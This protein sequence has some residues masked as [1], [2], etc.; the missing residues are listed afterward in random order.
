MVEGREEQPKGG[1]GMTRRDFLGSIVEPFLHQGD[2]YRNLDEQDLSHPDTAVTKVVH[3]IARDLDTLD[4]GVPPPPPDSFDLRCRLPQENID[5]ILQ[6]MRRDQLVQVMRDLWLDTVAIRLF[7]GLTRFA[8]GDI[9]PNLIYDVKALMNKIANPDIDW[10]TVWEETKPPDKFEEFYSY[11][12]PRL[13][14]G[15]IS[16]AEMI[17]DFVKKNITTDLEAEQDRLHEWAQLIT[18]SFLIEAAFLLGISVSED[19][20]IEII[21]LL[22]SVLIPARFLLGNPLNNAIEGALSPDL[23][24]TDVIANPVTVEGYDQAQRIVQEMRDSGPPATVLLPSDEHVFVHDTSVETVPGSCWLD[25]NRFVFLTDLNNPGIIRLPLRPDTFGGLRVVGATG[26]VLAEGTEGNL[27]RVPATINFSEDVELQDLTTPDSPYSDSL[28]LILE[29]IRRPIH[30]T[31]LVR[32]RILAT[33]VD[34]NIP[35]ERA[36][37]QLGYPSRQAIVSSGFSDAYISNLVQEGRL[38][39][40]TYRDNSFASEIVIIGDQ[41]YII[42]E[43]LGNGSDQ[44]LIVPAE[45]FAMK[46]EN[47]TLGSKIVKPGLTVGGIVCAAFFTVLLAIRARERLHP[48]QSSSNDEESPP[49]EEES[50]SGE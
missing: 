35:I 31:Q 42:F 28:A 8:A 39:E 40:F 37:A 44:R 19:R 38:V 24:I 43:P 41:A 5:F 21:Y 16:H 9:P 10:D 14:F 23:G 3:D 29:I 2:R 32:K 34:T 36:I 11:D 27:I 22:D 50:P 7:L 18:Y 45:I 15:S 46:M 1:K 30:G 17:L 20:M 6:G 49:D 25:R 33:P 4:F 26:V 13:I 47:Q 48:G 12:L